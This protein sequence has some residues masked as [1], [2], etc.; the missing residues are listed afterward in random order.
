LSIGEHSEVLR[1][2]RLTRT[3]SGTPVELTRSTYRGDRYVFISEMRG[4]YSVL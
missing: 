4:K 1:L 3:A 2:E